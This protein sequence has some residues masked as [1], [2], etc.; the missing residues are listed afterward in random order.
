MIRNGLCSEGMTI[1]QVSQNACPDGECVLGLFLSQAKLFNSQGGNTKGILTA[2]VSRYDEQL[3][4]RT[5][6]PLCTVE[7]W[8]ATLGK[9]AV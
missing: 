8:L 2:E 5:A 3:A 6:P 1:Q 7:I 4:L 9:G